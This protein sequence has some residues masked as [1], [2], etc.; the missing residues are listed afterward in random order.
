MDEGSPPT[1]ARRTMRG[2]CRSSRRLRK[3]GRLG[4]SRGCRSIP[5]QPT[6]YLQ[7]GQFHMVAAAEQTGKLVG[8]VH[9]ITPL[10]AIYPDWPGYLF[11]T[12]AAIAAAVLT[13]HWLAARL[14][15]QI[16]GPIVNLAHT[17]QR[18]SLEEDYSLRVERSSED[19]IGSLIDGF[20]QMLAQIRHRDSGWNGTANSSNN[21]SRSAPTISAM[22]TGNCSVQSARPRVPKKPRKEQAARRANSWPG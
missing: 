15:Q 3:P 18:V 10:E 19:E 1:A 7:S 20:N 6:L 14:Q 13:S 16:S 17:M 4:C 8:Y 9:V 5:R 12:A 22:P 11:I 21:R 2:M